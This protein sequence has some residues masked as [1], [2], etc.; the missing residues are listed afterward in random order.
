[1]L[2]VLFRAGGILY[3][4]DA[5]RVVEVVPRVASRPVPHAPPWMLGLLS[6]RG[7]IVPMIDFGVLTG[8][9]PSRQ[10][11]S[12]RAIL[13]N[14][15]GGAGVSRL[16][17]LVA[18]DVSRVK[19]VKDG[20]GSG[21]ALRLGAAPYLGA[22]IRLDEGLVQLVDVDRLPTDAATTSEGG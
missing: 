1:M 17:G 8:A 20:N 14:A 3:G 11:L 21:P 15:A 5:L 18:D 12:T 4:V 19:T 7:R 13:A 2:L 10:V 16:I 6:Y 22:L 9:A